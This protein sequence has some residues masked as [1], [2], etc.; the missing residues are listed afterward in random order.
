MWQNNGAK[1]TGCLQLREIDHD[2]VLE[3]EVLKAQ[4][5]RKDRNPLEGEMFH[6]RK[7][8]AKHTHV[9]AGLG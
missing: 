7:Q 5:A 6:K 1:K 8:K 9:T 3:I 4:S 2:Q